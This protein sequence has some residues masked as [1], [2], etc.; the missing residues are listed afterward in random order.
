[1][2]VQIKKLRPEAVVP[3]YATPG[4]ACFDLHAITCESAV[5][6]NALV[7]GT[8]LAFEVPEG[9][10]MLIFSRSGHGFK[11]DVRL[12]NCVGVI[13][14]DYRGEV[15]VKLTCDRAPGQEDLRVNTGDRVAQAMVL[16]VERV[17]FVVVDELSDTERG[18][19]GFGSTGVATLEGVA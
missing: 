18:E 13:D 3:R 2:K 1:M 19:A 15:K 16:P 8:G 9:H 12:A 6:P 11:N 5:S 4:S 17:Q 14:A 7:F 10:A